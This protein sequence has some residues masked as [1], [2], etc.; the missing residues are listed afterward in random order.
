[1]G[2][3]RC[4]AFVLQPTSVLYVGRFCEIAMK[5]KDTYSDHFNINGAISTGGH[6][7]TMLQ[8]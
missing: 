3:E 7:T 5:Q 6:N 2:I 4:H 8:K 1:M